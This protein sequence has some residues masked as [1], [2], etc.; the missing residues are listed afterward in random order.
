MKERS[1]RTRDSMMFLNRHQ[2]PVNQQPF[3]PQPVPVPTAPVVTDRSVEVAAQLRKEL[4]EIT[5]KYELVQDESRLMR[6]QVTALKEGIELLKQARGDAQVSLEAERN[7]M[8]QDRASLAGKVKTLEASQ[9]TLSQTLAQA[10]AER[11]AA[12]NQRAE[13]QL[14]ADGLETALKELQQRLDE[15]TKNL[16]EATSYKPAVDTAAPPSKVWVVEV[17][18]RSV[19]NSTIT[20]ECRLHFGDVDAA[21]EGSLTIP[22]SELLKLRPQG[23]QHGGQ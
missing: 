1:G 7:S 4:K 23:K 15:T 14:K 18:T 10:Q 6:Q 19:E 21:L 11:L 20:A 12:E 22:Y 3:I 17:K 9:T 16:D 13:Y 5:K 2:L 8:A